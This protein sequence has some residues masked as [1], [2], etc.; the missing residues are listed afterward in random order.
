MV[1][2]NKIIVI[3][4][5]VLAIGLGVHAL[6]TTPVD[7]IPDLSDVQVIVYTEAK[8][9]IAANRGRSSTRPRAQ[10]NVVPSL[11]MM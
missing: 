8:R 11:K 10:Y 7:A 9:T 1:N 6:M 5:T 4:L 3:F 2:R